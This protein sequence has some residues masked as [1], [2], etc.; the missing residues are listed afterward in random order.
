MSCS[1]RKDLVS[2]RIPRCVAVFG[3]GG[4]AVVSMLAAGFAAYSGRAH[5]AAT[6]GP[7][8]IDDATLKAMTT[9][10][11]GA[12]PQPTTR[13]LTHWFGQTLNPDNGVT[14]GYN[15][16]GADPNNCS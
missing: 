6:A 10:L 8:M 9:T 4:L 7:Q 2:M 5:A 11:G 3:L 14:Y 1:R 16:V 15:M 13:T 12:R